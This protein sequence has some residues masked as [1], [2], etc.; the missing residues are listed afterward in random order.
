M[1]N[2]YP[3]CAI[4]WGSAFLASEPVELRAIRCINQALATMFLIFTTRRSVC[5]RSRAESEQ[6]CCSLLM[7]R[8]IGGSGG[9]ELLRENQQI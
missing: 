5:G 9:D 7:F 2:P 6:S 3:F 8:S 4:T 1:P